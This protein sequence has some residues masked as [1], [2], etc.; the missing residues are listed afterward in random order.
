MQ[1]FLFA[2]TRNNICYQTIGKAILAGLKISRL[3]SSSFW[4]RASLSQNILMLLY[5]ILLLL[6]FLTKPLN[7]SFT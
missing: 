6:Q 4:E 3:V 2:A 7:R 1:C 5:T